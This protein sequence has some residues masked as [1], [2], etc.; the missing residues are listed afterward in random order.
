MPVFLKDSPEGCGD[1]SMWFPGAN[2]VCSHLSW[3]RAEPC[4]GVNK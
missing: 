3:R 4:C 2:T 1:S